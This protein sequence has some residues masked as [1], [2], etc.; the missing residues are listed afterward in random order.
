MPIRFIVAF[1]RRSLSDVALAEV[2]QRHQ[3]RVPPL[4]GGYMQ[5]QK[6]YGLVTGYIN[7]RLYEQ[8]LL[9]GVEEETRRVA[10]H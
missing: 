8:A 6:R 3:L 1:M 9:Q 10:R 5:A 4:S 2:W 7:I